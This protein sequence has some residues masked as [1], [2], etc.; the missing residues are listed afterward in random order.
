MGAMAEL[1]DIAQVAFNGNQEQCERPAKYRFTQKGACCLDGASFIAYAESKRSSVAL[2]SAP[3]LR[4]RL[5]ERIIILREIL[6]APGISATFAMGK[7]RI[8][9]VPVS[10]IEVTDE[11]GVLLQAQVNIGDLAHPIMARQTYTLSGKQFCTLVSD[12]NV[13]DPEPA[14]L[15]MAR[16]MLARQRSTIS[17]EEH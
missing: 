10:I 2:R 17:P 9:G 5:R 11:G 8:Q 13:P 6:L 1:C 7:L 14:G 15:L 4:P 16:N 3:M 12:R